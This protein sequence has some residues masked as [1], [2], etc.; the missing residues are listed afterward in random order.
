M[1]YRRQ[2]VTDFEYAQGMTRRAHQFIELRAKLN[3]KGDRS[4]HLASI[5]LLGIW[6]EPEFAHLFCLDPCVHPFMKLI[7][8]KRRSAPHLRLLNKGFSAGQPGRIFKRKR[9]EP[10]LGPN[11]TICLQSRILKNTNALFGVAYASNQVDFR[12]F[13]CTE[14]VPISKS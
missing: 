9:G 10:V 6:R 7:I 5:L 11:L 13:S 4:I 3:L 12:S 1:T 8:S 14:V 2:I